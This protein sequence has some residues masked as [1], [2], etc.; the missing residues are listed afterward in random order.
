MRLLA[1]MAAGA[2]AIAGTALADEADP[3]AEFV[4]PVSGDDSTF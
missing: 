1:W 3:F 2:L 4:S